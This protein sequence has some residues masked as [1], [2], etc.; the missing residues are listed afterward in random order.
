MYDWNMLKNYRL[1]LAIFALIPL[2][3]EGFNLSILPS[4]YN[5]IVTLILSILVMGGILNN[6]NTDKVRLKE[7]KESESCTKKITS[8]EVEEEKK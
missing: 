3:L 8:S 5:E 6:P 7:D 4:N 2:I 1:W